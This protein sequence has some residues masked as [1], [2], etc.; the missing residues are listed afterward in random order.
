MSQ[1]AVNMGES[2]HIILGVSMETVHM[3]EK[4]KGAGAT[5]ISVIDYEAEV[6]MFEMSTITFYSPKL[7]KKA[8]GNTKKVIFHKLIDKRM[9]G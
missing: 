7:A 3:I 2:R 8:V 9:K 6:D 5:D 4:L 1:R